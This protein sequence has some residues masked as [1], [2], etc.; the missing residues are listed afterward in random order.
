MSAYLVSDNTINAILPYLFSKEGRFLGDPALG[1][2]SKEELGKRMAHLNDEAMD[3][4]YG[5]GTA[6]S[7]R[8]I[9]RAGPAVSQVTALKQL[10]CWIYQCSQGSVPDSPLYRALDKL[11]FETLAYGIAGSLPEYTAAPWGMP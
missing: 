5:A 7:D 3:A 1:I 11:S 8:Y 9:Y 10:R 2:D 6:A 4:R